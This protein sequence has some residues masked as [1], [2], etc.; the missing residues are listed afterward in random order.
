MVD[1]VALDIIAH[2]LS[3]KGTVVPPL[4]SRER[5]CIKLCVGLMKT[6]DPNTHSDKD[7]SPSGGNLLLSPFSDTMDVVLQ[8]RRRW[9]CCKI[10]LCRKGGRFCYHPPHTDS[11][12]WIC[13]KTC[14]GS[15]NLFL[16][17]SLPNQSSDLDHIYVPNITTESITSP[18]PF[19]PFHQSFAPV[20][21]LPSCFSFVTSTTVPSLH[22]MRSP[23]VW[24]RQAA[25]GVA[26]SRWLR[27]GSVE[28]VRVTIWTVLIG[29]VGIE[30]VRFRWQK[31]IK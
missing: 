24:C 2:T 9:L 3:S 22:R 1:L 19:I 21:L 17:K 20:S 11:Q 4:W 16:I 18:I 25:P 23:W 31:W 5:M 27:L 28:A 30:T 8:S 15:S 7:N 6:G 12:M 14:P 26:G 13:E 29:L 10:R